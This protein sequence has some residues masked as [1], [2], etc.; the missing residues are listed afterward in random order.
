MATGYKTS[1]DILGTRDLD[2]EFITDAWLIDQYVGNTLFGWGDNSYGAI[3]N[4]T[5]TDYSSP[6]QIGNLTNWKQVACGYKHTVVIKTDG[7]LWVCGRNNKGQLGNGTITDYSSP[8]QIGNLTNWKQIAGGGV[9]TVALTFNDI[10][11]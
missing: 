3:G 5:Q 2:E 9:L 10:G 8:I 11:T 1:N 7:T 4:G 6:I